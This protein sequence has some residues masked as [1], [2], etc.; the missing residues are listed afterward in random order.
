MKGTLSKIAIFAVGAAV[1]SAVTYKYLKTTYEKLAE[2][3]IEE[4]REYYLGKSQEVEDTV[5]EEKPEVAKRDPDQIKK[6][7]QAYATIVKN[8]GYGESDEFE[9]KVDEVDKPYVIHPDEFGEYADYEQITLTY[10]ADG[11]LADDMDEI[12]DDVDGAV[13]A[14]FMDHYGEYEDDTV[15][16][17]NDE[18]MCDYEI[19]R[20]ERDYKE[21]VGDYP[22][23]AEVE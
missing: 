4:M 6:D 12:I 21:V 16:V 10:Y 2:K 3:E 15:F 20:D 17:R 9:R 11:I 8:M 18:R 13:G 7:I 5:S 23:Q 14:N 1:G 19:Q 22:H